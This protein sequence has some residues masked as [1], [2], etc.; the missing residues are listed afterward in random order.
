[1]ARI[2]DYQ[3]DRDLQLQDKVLGTDYTN[4]GTMNF[5]LEQLGA[6]LASRG[7]ADPSSLDL[8][9]EFSGMTEP[10]GIQPGQIYYN[11]TEPTMLTQVW[12]SNV[13][14]KGI[15]SGPFASYLP[16]SVIEINDA[17]SSSGTDYGFYNVTSVTEFIAGTGYV[18]NVSVHIPQ[19]N[20]GTDLV[21]DSTS[22][23]PATDFINLSI[24]GFTGSQGLTGNT[25]PSVRARETQ[26]GNETTDTKFE[27][28]YVDYL[29]DPIDEDI[30]PPV[31]I[32]ISHGAQ[33]EQ[34]IQGFQGDGVTFKEGTS[35]QTPGEVSSIVFTNH[36]LD[37][38]TGE[39]VDTDQAAVE[40]QPGNDGES[41][42]SITGV[43]AVSGNAIPNVGENTTVTVT[44]DGATSDDEFTVAHG[45]QG[46]QG[47]NITGVTPDKATP[48]AGEEV[49]L[50]FNTQDP[51]N[52]DLAGTLDP[53]TIPAGAQGFEGPYNL[54]I[55]KAIDDS[56]IS[57]DLDAPSDVSY[58]Y[59]TDTFTPSLD[60]GWSQDTG[61]TSLQTLYVR[62]FRVVP[63]SISGT[64][65]S[66]FNVAIQTGDWSGTFTAGT[67]GSEG[68]Q[69]PQG[70]GFNSGTNTA[71][72]S[73]GGATGQTTTFSVDIFDPADNDNKTGTLTF[74]VPAGAS[75]SNGV[76]V[77][78]V[79][80]VIS[81][82]DY[83]EDTSALSPGENILIGFEG[84]DNSELGT[85]T[86]PGG[87][88]GEEGDQGFQGISITA[89][90]GDQ[91]DNP[92]P[93]SPTNV[94]IH[95]NDPSKSDGTFTDSFVVSPGGTGPKGDQGIF[96]VSLYT[97]SENNP[98]SPTG[99]RYSLSANEILDFSIPD[100]WEIDPYDNQPGEDF[101]LWESRASVDPSIE[102]TVQTLAF[103]SSFETGNAGPMGTPG[104]GI[105]SIVP[106]PINGPETIGGM[107]FEEGDVEI[108][109]NYTDGSDPVVFGIASGDD[110]EQGPQGFY[111][112]FIYRVA[113]TGT[114][115]ST[116]APTNAPYDEDAAPDLW[117][118]ETQTP[119]V[120]EVV[121]ISTAVV[122][123]SDLTSDLNWSTPFPGSG[124]AGPQ[125]PQGLKG[126]PGP[127]VPNGGV[128]GAVLVK[129]EDGDQVT[130]WVEF[131]EEPS[132][133]NVKFTSNGTK[134]FA[135]VDLTAY[136]PLNPSGG[137]GGTTTKSAYMGVQGSAP[138]SF[139]A[140]SGLTKI[141]GAAHDGQAVTFTYTD[142][143][144]D[145]SDNWLILNLPNDLVV[146]HTVNFNFRDP[147]SGFI[148]PLSEYVSFQD[149]TAEFT[150]YTVS[151]GRTVTVITHIS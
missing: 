32:T 31:E 57:P 47:I 107:N 88:K 135:D 121:F 44:Y 123:P 126:D 104:V 92:R 93:G 86:I 28:Y 119:G 91:D 70:I 98:G 61:H 114:D 102:G 146:G 26:A 80:R 35:G 19:D 133:G 11:S 58:N 42:T 69:G 2:K 30:I 82:S 8:Q 20:S 95:L 150:T 33:G 38:N 39:I 79:K 60:N 21:I 63:S 53:V 4:N 84:T 99:V 73:S 49:A 132:L 16:G 15:D 148:L 105:S 134:I 94:T 50:T 101:P 137:S 25:G 22:S 68:G 45:S 90:E 122:D 77:G 66:N 131:D 151:F 29:G 130:S 96:N 54:D 147:Q 46:F 40:I 113:A 85:V 141:D 18:L 138:E 140:N 109:I 136:T 59:K 97:R 127:G 78:S 120:D 74:T 103:G 17:V 142:I 56:D 128:K 34:G 117:S 36:V 55:Y 118:Y 52:S 13:D 143:N 24:I 76:S 129:T 3:L 75:G 65:A 6:F 139:V 71:T 23:V 111:T 41:V 115:V 100:P 64:D 110:G 81:S 106:E 14:L 124:E 116:I 9:F 87:A 5:S 72:V 67:Q 10:S 7:L 27:L 125:G 89:I 51:A 149:D 108:T 145:D 43:G 37:D 62:R 48:L 1:M 83:T 144:S 112:V 12:I